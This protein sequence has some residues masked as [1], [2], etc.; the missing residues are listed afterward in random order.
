MR[1]RMITGSTHAAGLIMQAIFLPRKRPPAA[2]LRSRSVSMWL[3]ST[4]QAGR[5][6][7]FMVCGCWMRF[8]DNDENKTAGELHADTDRLTGRQLHFENFI[9][10]FANVDVIS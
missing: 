3:C 4:N 1:S 9:I 2:S 6:T 8:V 10:I 5:M 7:R